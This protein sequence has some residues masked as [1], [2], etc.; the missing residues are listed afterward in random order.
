MSS[1]APSPPHTTTIASST[2][3]KPE[4]RGQRP[5]AS[6]PAEAKGVRWTVTPNALTG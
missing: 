6:A 4:C 2:S 5:D 3:P 1:V